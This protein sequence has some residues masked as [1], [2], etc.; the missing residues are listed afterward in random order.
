MTKEHLEAEYSSVL[1]KIECLSS[2]A[3]SI[4]TQVD[5]GPLIEAMTQANNLALKLSYPLP[6]P[7]DLLNKLLSEKRRLQHYAETGND[8]PSLK[9]VQ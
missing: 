1:K 8:A 7:E 5:L 9:L 4:G 6:Y 3:R 2:D